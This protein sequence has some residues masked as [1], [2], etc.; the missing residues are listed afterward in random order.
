MKLKQILPISNGAFLNRYNLELTL[1][2][3]RTKLYEMV[4]RRP[5]HSAADLAQSEP[6]GVVL[7]I[8]SPDRN[9]V[10]LNR[11]YRP[12]VAKTVYN[13]PAGLI[14]PGET[15]AQAASRELREETGLPLAGEL[16]FWERSYGAVGISNESSV[17]YVGLADDRLPF[18]GNH[19]PAEEICPVWVDR[20][21]AQ[22]IIQSG[23]VTARVQLFLAMWSTDLPNAPAKLLQHEPD[24][25]PCRKETCG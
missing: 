11:E 22:S 19:D 20:S 6:E 17:V 23:D 7:I 15:P 18:G 14:D 16:A 13:F 4:S 21:Q 25:T 2:N 8:L 12:A 24:K 3:G 9:R 10:L 1:Q 5:V